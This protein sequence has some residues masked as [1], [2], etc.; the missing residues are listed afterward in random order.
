ML[1]VERSR[2]PAPA[3]LATVTTSVLRRAAPAPTPA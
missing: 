3:T 2:V 1:E